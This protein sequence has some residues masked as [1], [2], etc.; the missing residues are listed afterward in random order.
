M[1]LWRVGELSNPPAQEGN[2]DSSANNHRDNWVCWQSSSHVQQSSQKCNNPL[3]LEFLMFYSNQPKQTW[4]SSLSGTGNSLQSPGP[5]TVNCEPFPCTNTIT[6]A[7]THNRRFSPHLPRIFCS[8]LIKR[9]LRKLRLKISKLEQQTLAR[10]CNYSLGLSV[11]IVLK[12]SRIWW[13]S[14]RVYLWGCYL[15]G[16]AEG[17]NPPPMSMACAILWHGIS[18]RTQKNK[19]ESQW[20]THTLLVIFLIGSTVG[21]LCSLHRRQFLLMQCLP[22][23]INYVLSNQWASG[24]PSPS[25]CQRVAYSPSGFLSG[26]WW[27]NTLLSSRLS[28]HTPTPFAT[29]SSQWPTIIVLP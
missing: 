4:L 12:M 6:L 29:V 21:K 3:T 1:L 9:V 7:T 20:G 15:K 25:S 13:S 27:Y 10:Q 2:A 23:R 8:K 14:P 11:R 22:I 19:E 18:D 28:V 5:A 24:K 16:I 26:V 17:D